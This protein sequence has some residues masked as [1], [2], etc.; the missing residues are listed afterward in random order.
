MV[1]FDML[2]TKAE[3][4]FKRYPQLVEIMNPVHETPLFT[5]YQSES[6]A[7]GAADGTTISDSA[8]GVDCFGVDYDTYRAYIIDKD[9]SYCNEERM[10]DQDTSGGTVH[11]STAFPGKIAAGVGYRI[12]GIAITDV[13]AHESDKGMDARLHN[14]V[15]IHVENT[16]DDSV[17][18]QLMGG[19]RGT[20]TGART[21]G[22]SFN[23]AAGDEETRVHHAD[24]GWGEWLYLVA[25][26][27]I[28][29]TTGILFCYGLLRNI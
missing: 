5:P 13:A 6:D 27:P 11:V 9:S 18:I 4:L 25:T 23:V 2:K 24:K 26:C 16:L 22:P 29:P 10:I 1:E 21:I 17:S 28:A 3:R 7:D 20:T 15:E 8:L 14:F 12:N 19:R